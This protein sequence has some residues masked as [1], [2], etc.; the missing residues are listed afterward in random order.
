MMPTTP[1]HMTP[2]T[3]SF[4]ARRNHWQIQWFHHHRSNRDSAAR[5]Y[6]VIADV[7]AGATVGHVFTASVASP[8]DLTTTG[9]PTGTAA[10]NQQTVSPAPNDLTMATANGEPATISSLANDAT[11]TT[12]SQGV[13]AWQIAFNNPA[14][15][16][17]AGTLSAL[18]LTPGANNGSPTGQP[19]FRRRSYSMAPRPSPPE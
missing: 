16:A 1:G 8:S 9:T 4:P 7:A 15:N 2:G 11:I 10:G 6:L 5:R 19:P 12:S 3:V 17:G 13:P 14:G 18:T